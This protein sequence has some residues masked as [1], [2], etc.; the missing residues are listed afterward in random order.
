MG[1]YNVFG[2][3]FFEVDIALSR[4]FSILERLNME[5]RGEAFNLTNSFRPGNTTTGASGLTTTLNSGTFGQVL[6]ALDPRIMQVAV[7][8]AF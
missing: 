3:K 2:P 6:N 4:R 7:K 8:F 1:P 5:I